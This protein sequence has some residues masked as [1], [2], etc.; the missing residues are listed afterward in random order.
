MTFVQLKYF[1]EIVRHGSI[2]AAAA[3]CFISYHAMHKSLKNLETELNLSLLYRTPK[4]ISLTEEG[5][6]FYADALKIL[7]LE[8]GWKQLSNKQHGEKR[9]VAEIYST[10]FFIFTDTLQTIADQLSQQNIFIDYFASFPKMIEQLLPQKSPE[11]KTIFLTY[12]QPPKYNSIRL[13]EKNNYHADYLCADFCKILLHK[14][15]VAD[16]TTAL[17]LTDLQGFAPIM[18]SNSYESW[19]PFEVDGLIDYKKPYHVTQEIAQVFALLEQHKAYCLLRSS[20]YDHL[21]PKYGDTI[22]ALDIADCDTKTE[23]YMLYPQNCSAT[24]QT[25]ADA[26]KTYC[27]NHFAAI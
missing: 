18:F 10:H 11:Q 9:Q 27:K 4:G 23:Y 22:V 2:N 26:I 6:K 20:V 17:Q 12:Q 19:L 7:E 5:E 16:G 21:A 1:C 13:A 8:Q 14:K 15:W 3:A 24:E 25:V